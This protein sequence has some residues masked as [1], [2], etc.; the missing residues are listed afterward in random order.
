MTKK[1]KVLRDPYAGPGLLMVE[2]QQYRFGLEDVWRSDVP[3]KPGLAV[4]VE[5]NSQ[6]EISSITAVRESEAN[7]RSAGP[8]EKDREGKDLLRMLVKQIGFPDLLAVSL[9]VISWFFMTALS[10]EVPLLGK[11][12]ATMWQTLGYLNSDGVLESFGRRQAPSPGLWGLL[13]VLAIA[14]PF[15]HRFWKD[16]PALW[17][18]LM[19]LLF[20][21]LVGIEVR[22]NIEAS[23]ASATGIFAK[24]AQQEFLRGVS[25][26][27]GAYVSLLG[28]SYFAIR[29]TIR[30]FVAKQT[31]E[32][33][34]ATTQRTAA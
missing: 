24:Q 16:K 33:P 4:E 28:S 14:G 25:L 31:V 27:S 17:G 9:L 3:P 21:L 13:A 26:G 20:M 6:S 10:I 30:Y 23:I 19:P 29:S 15:V 22:S 1:G 32:K 8:G 18:G 2:G 12:D 7:D 11:M 34:F 5:F